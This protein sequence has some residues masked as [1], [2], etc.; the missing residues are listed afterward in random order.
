MQT[1]G[2]N[3]DIQTQTQLELNKVQPDNERKIDRLVDNS[4]NRQE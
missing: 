3:R 2:D 1:R 4:C